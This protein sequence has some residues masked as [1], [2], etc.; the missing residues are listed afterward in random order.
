MNT[1]SISPLWIEF[2][3]PALAAGLL[4]GGLMMWLVFRSRQRRLR[5]TIESLSDRIKDQDALIL[6]DQRRYPATTKTRSGAAA[7]C[8]SDNRRTLGKDCLC[9]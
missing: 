9:R 2:G 5:E 8:Q 6:F 7:A 3:G 4:L 1:I